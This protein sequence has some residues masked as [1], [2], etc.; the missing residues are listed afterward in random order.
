[1]VR[2]KRQS[3]V[4]MVNGTRPVFG[5]RDA[6]AQNIAIKNCAVTLKL[7]RQTLRHLLTDKYIVMINNIG[8]HHA[9]H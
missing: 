7:T 4:E 9:T 3:F 2:V 5:P 8:F 1:M 6:L